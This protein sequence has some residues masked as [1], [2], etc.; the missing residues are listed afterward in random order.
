MRMLVHP[1]E[2]RGPMAAFNGGIIVM[3]N[4][5]IVGGP[6]AAALR[7]CDTPDSE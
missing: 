4:M 5:T 2:M 6:V 3:P 1:L 7:G